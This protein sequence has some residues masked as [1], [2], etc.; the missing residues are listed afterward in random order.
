MEINITFLLQKRSNTK[1]RAMYLLLGYNIT[2][3]H[4]TRAIVSYLM[5]NSEPLN[6]TTLSLEF[7]DLVALALL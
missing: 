6:P 2:P 1:L 7:V 4:F 3:I 5:I